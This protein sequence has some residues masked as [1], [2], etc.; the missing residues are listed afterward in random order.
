MEAQWSR[1]AVPPFLSHS[2]IS[3]CSTAAQQTQEYCSPLH[4]SLSRA[5]TWKTA[6]R[7]TEVDF[8][9]HQGYAPSAAVPLQTVLWSPRT[10]Q[11]LQAH[12]QHPEHPNSEGSATAQHFS[13]NRALL[14]QGMTSDGTCSATRDVS[15]EWSAGSSHRPRW[16]SK[17]SANTDQ[18]WILFQQP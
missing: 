18:S 5:E 4:N 17:Q 13:L 14:P 6:L 3:G 16:F 15:L 12:L 9:K 10:C 7:A 1:C 2:D 11:Y 8:T